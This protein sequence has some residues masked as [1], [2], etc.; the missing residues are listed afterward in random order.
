[1]IEFLI[2]IID[3]YAK[4]MKCISILHKNLNNLIR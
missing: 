4:Y 3:I 1:M 2:I